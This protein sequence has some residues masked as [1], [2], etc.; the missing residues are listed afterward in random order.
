[1]KETSYFFLIE[2]VEKT[3]LKTSKNYPAFSFLID[4]FGPITFFLNQDNAN[5][6]INFVK[7]VFILQSLMVFVYF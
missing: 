4:N 2:E 3:C 7:K 6:N 1:M 5:K